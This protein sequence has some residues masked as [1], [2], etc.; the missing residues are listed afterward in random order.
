L[1][2]L[3][4]CYRHDVAVTRYSP[5]EDFVKEA[6]LRGATVACHDPLVVHWAELDRKLPPELPTTDG[7][8]A[9]VFG[10]PHREYQALDVV[11]WLGGK[12]PLVFDANAVLPKA[13]RAGLVKAG[14]RVFSIGRGEEVSP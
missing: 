12:K 7:V 11:S 14:V 4:V 6:E 10:V 2:L 1:L 5:S 8:D 13:T 9:V 3:G